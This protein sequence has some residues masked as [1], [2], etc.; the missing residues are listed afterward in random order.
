[1]LGVKCKIYLS[2]VTGATQ[3]SWETHL[4][5]LIQLEKTLTSLIPTQTHCDG[6]EL[7]D[8]WEDTQLGPGVTDG[9]ILALKKQEIFKPEY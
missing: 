5:G 4:F 3:E 6:Q 8:Q 9:K 1:M 2:L 7:G